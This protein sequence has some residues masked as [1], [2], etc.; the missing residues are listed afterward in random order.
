M[1]QF[2]EPRN[3]SWIFWDWFA[4]ISDLRKSLGSHFSWVSLSLTL[5]PYIE[6]AGLVTFYKEMEKRFFRPNQIFCFSQIIFRCKKKQTTQKNCTLQWSWNAS[7][8]RREGTNFNHKICEPQTSINTQVDTTHKC[9]HIHTYT[10]TQRPV[11]LR[12][13]VMEEYWI[14]TVGERRGCNFK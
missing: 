11:L 10:H 12:K 3:K 8:H 5:Y 13:L 14:G 7:L 4:Q 1:L 2:S 6:I 9:V